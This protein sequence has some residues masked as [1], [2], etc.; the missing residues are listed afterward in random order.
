M[1]S[2]REMIIKQLHSFTS[3]NEEV[4]SYHHS[5]NG[6]TGLSAVFVRTSSLFE[7]LYTT[8]RTRVLRVQTPMA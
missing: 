5:A 8:S 7:A 1:F 2:F 6:P 4:G 3:T